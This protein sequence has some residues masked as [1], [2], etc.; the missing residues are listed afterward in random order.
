MKSIRIVTFDNYFEGRH[1]KT[2]GLYN[3]HT[4]FITDNKSND[5]L[6]FDTPDEAY[7]HAK[8][9]GINRVYITT[10]TGKKVYKP[11]CECEKRLE[12]G[13][14]FKLVKSTDY[15]Q[16]PWEVKHYWTD[17]VTIQSRYFTTKQKALDYMNGKSNY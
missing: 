4:G 16:T 8:H 1:W 10:E 12:S 17:G 2:Y 9:L 7:F 14:I 3:N 13:D 11:S 15:R 5:K 6:L